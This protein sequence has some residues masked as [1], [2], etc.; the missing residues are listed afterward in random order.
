M[1]RVAHQQ[2]SQ[3]LDGG[4]RPRE[5][6]RKNTYDVGQTTA[7]TE[8]NTAAWTPQLGDARDQDQGQSGQGGRQRAQVHE[9]HED[10][11]GGRLQELRY[12]ARRR[13]APAFTGTTH[14]IGSG[15]RSSPQEPHEDT[16]TAA[17]L[18]L[19]EEIKTWDKKNAGLFHVLVLTTVGAAWSTVCRFEPKE[20]ETAN[21]QAPWRAVWDK[22]EK[23]LS[24]RR[25]VPVRKFNR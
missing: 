9:G 13:P 11:G 16:T 17:G 12:T 5:V 1:L 23:N 21:G 14:R 20:G 3:V 25:R 6:Y 15:G 24:Q 18:V 7:A 19:N 4:A 10:H 22:Y 2:V 8:E